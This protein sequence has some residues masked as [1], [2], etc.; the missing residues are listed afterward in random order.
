MISYR[1]SRLRILYGI[2]GETA[3]VLALMI[4]GAGDE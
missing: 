2:R 1:T 4:W 3:A